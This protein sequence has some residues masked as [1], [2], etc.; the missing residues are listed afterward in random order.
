VNDFIT[1]NDQLT[2]EQGIVLRE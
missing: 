2:E 1:T